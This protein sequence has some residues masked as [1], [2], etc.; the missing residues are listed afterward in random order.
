MTMR[1][2][3]RFPI[4][5]A[6]YRLLY[7]VFHASKGFHICANLFGQCWDPVSEFVCGNGT[8]RRQTRMFAAQCKGFSLPTCFS[9]AQKAAEILV[10]RSFEIDRI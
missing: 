3:N 9:A 6:L 1:W 8:F 10:R 2:Q 7:E 5:A 4:I